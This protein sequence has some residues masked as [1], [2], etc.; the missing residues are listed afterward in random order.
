MAD[1]TPRTVINRLI[2]TC[3][4]SERGFIA[5]AD[6]AAD[7]ELRAAFLALA[8]ERG[9][10]AEE[11]QSHAQRLGGESASDGTTSAA[12]HRRWMDLKARLTGY[13]DHAVLTEVL[14][15]DSVT[16]RTYE[17]ALRGSLP[18]AVREIVLGQDEALRQAH[19]HLVALDEARAPR[20]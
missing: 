8:A 17:T 3:R 19:D 15:G 12:I 6:L 7:L 5:A 20:S 13:D 16:L 4:D 10:W 9:T 1:S 14:R 11:L 2:D 18:P